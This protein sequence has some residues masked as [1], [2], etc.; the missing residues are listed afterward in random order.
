MDLNPI[1]IL[2]ALVGSGI[3]YVYFSFGRS[4]SDWPM[5]ASG[6]ALMTYSY[7]ITSPLDLALVG[8]VIAVIPFA[9]RRFVG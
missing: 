3:G 8:A 2:A 5:V 9:I 6:I 4:Q 7:F 1:S